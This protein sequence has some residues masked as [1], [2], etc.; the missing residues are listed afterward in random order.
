MNSS[1]VLYYRR[2]LRLALT[3]IRSWE[4][5]LIFRTMLSKDVVSHLNYLR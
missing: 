4:R 3:S 1:N 5:G 2:D